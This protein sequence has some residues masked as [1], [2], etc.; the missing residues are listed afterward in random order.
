MSVREI[1]PFPRGS[2]YNQD[3]V[4]TM[5]ASY[6][7]HLEGKIY[8]VPDTVHG[9]GQTVKL[10]IVRNAGSEITAAN[11][12]YEFDTNA[13]DFGRVI[14]TVTDGVGEPCKPL[15]DDYTAGK[16]I[17]QYDLL[18]VVESGLCSILMEDATIASAQWDAMTPAA[19]GSGEVDKT[20]AGDGEYVVG[21]A[22][23][24]PVAGENCVIL[25]KEGLMNAEG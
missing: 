7:D 3:G 18:Y 11:V 22:T 10:R 12:L 19:A 9:T 1:L 20:K 2:T 24:T 25:V 4:L 14:N 15:D 23:A 5:T 6:A 17:A 16:K 8:E 13:L 21:T